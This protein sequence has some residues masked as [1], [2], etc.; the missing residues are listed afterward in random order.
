MVAYSAAVVFIEVS[1]PVC[2]GSCTR[3][4]N[5]LTA[6]ANGIWVIRADV[7]CT[8]LLDTLD[9]TPRWVDALSK[10]RH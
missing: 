1:S 6:I 4:W 3:P 2:I 5:P 7:T 8:T 9:P 10:Q